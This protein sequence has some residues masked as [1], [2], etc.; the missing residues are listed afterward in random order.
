MRGGRIGVLLVLGRRSRGKSLGGLAHRV[1]LAIAAGL[2]V[3]VGWLLIATHAEIGASH[4]RA[5]AR[6]PVPA[7]SGQARAYWLEHI[8]HLD[9]QQFLVIY[10]APIDATMAP[11]PGLSA[12]PRP[13]TYVM[14]PALARAAGR[15]PLSS[16]YGISAGTIAMSGLTDPDEWIMYARPAS[17]ADFA[18]YGRSALISGLGQPDSDQFATVNATPHS[19]AEFYRIELVLAVLPV[20]VLL[21]VALRGASEQRDRR[22]AM[23]EALGA[24]RRTTAWVLVGEAALPVLLGT[25]AAAGV[26]MLTTFTGVRV[27]I[28]GY[29]VIA[30]DLSGPR[31]AVAVLWITGALAVLAAVILTHIRG[32]GGGATRPRRVRDRRAWWQITVCL[33]A[34]VGCA[35]IANRASLSG[36]VHGRNGLILAFF[37][38]VLVV[39]AT[40]P[41][42]IAAGVTGL[43]TAAGRIGRRRGW[44]GAMVGG[45]WLA[46]RPGSLA[47]MCAAA[48]VGLGILAVVQVWVSQYQTAGTTSQVRQSIGAQVVSVQTGASPTQVSTFEAAVGTDRVVWVGEDSDGDVGLVGS[49]SALSSLGRLTCGPVPKPASALFAALTPVGAAVSRQNASILVSGDPIVSTRPLTG[50]T[51]SGFLVFNTAGRPGVDEV[52]DVA[53]RM[54]TLPQ[55]TDPGE[56]SVAGSIAE[57]QPYEWLW[58]LAAF[59][60]FVLLLAAALSAIDVVFTQ[61]ATIGVLGSFAAGRRLYLSVAMWSIAVP[62]MVATAFGMG[63]ADLLGTMFAR[64][65]GSGSVS[66]RL[67]AGTLTAMVVLTVIQ[68]AVCAE[69]VTRSVRAWRPVND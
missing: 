28:V 5:A 58:V 8:D 60:A 9:D 31:T 38:A 21:I 13:G 51:N 42:T 29:S 1:G 59:G 66:P 39:L 14:S 4:A 10:V 56:I 67:L 25:L 55:V 47:R 37:V 35:W 61:A 48:V 33:L 63:V 65:S 27:P 17:T 2:T 20:L 22:V 40:L 26:A 44:S 18:R 11:P 45:G 32:R 23:L 46:A 49:C 50:Y 69:A 6:E 68:T 16:R 52:A 64:M 12:W 19:T 41:A 24:A 57:V 54:L 36:G 30:A 3:L 43:G 15:G 34:F 53:F 62:V 7:G